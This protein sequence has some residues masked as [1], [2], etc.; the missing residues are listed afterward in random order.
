M[1]YNICTWQRQAGIEITPPYEGAKCIVVLV[2]IMDAYSYIF[3]T[4][5][6]EQI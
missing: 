2:E 5:S 1:Y 3:I 4:W 6:V